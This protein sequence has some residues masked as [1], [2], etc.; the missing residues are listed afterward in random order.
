MHAR[1]HT[2][3]GAHRCLCALD[4]PMNTMHASRS[5]CL[6]S[7]LCALVTVHANACVLCLPAAV[8]AC[9]CVVYK[10]MP[11][12]V[13]VPHSDCASRSSAA[14]GP[15]VS[16]APAHEGTRV[17]ANSHHKPTH[18]RLRSTSSD[19]QSHDFISVVNRCCNTQPLTKALG[20]AH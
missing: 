12:R 5:R 13:V 7:S 17:R 18:D 15:P 10:D 16:S 8:V 19:R 11:V 14:V 9:V 20:Q 2:G 6:A 3:A 4:H 1:V